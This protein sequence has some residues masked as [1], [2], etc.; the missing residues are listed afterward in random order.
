[1]ELGRVKMK[2]Q[3]KPNFFPNKMCNFRDCSLSITKSKLADNITNNKNIKYG[4]K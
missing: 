4:R 1:M 2:K 3:G